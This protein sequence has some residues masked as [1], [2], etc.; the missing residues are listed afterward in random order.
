MSFYFLSLKSFCISTQST[1]ILSVRIYGI[2]VGSF[3]VVTE[4]QDKSKENNG[5]YNTKIK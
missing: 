2:F 4:T 5:F 3:L 1:N